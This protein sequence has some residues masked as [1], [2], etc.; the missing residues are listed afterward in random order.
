MTTVG[1]L[2]DRKIISFHVLFQESVLR[3]LVL[4]GTVI[5]TTST[6]VESLAGFG[7]LLGFVRTKGKMRVFKIG[8]LRINFCLIVSDTTVAS[9]DS[10]VNFLRISR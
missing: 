8:R 3:D 6:I 1:L 10:V 5:C 7:C 4:E 2:S 9:T